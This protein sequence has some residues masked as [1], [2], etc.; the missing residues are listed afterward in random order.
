[1][2]SK[3][4]RDR[5]LVAVVTL[6]LFLGVF[7]AAGYSDKSGAEVIGKWGG[8][9]ASTA[10]LF[11]VIIRHRRKFHRRPSFWGTMV[12][13]LLCHFLVLLSLL[14]RV[15]HWRLAWWA[16]VTPVEYFLMAGVLMLLGYTPARTRR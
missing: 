6:G 15:E 7:W 9:T 1:M 11:T 13:L 4:W 14:Q 12:T 10:I 3:T 8:L 5:I 16:I 2:E